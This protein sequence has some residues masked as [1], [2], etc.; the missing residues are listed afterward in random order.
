MNTIKSIG[1]FVLSIL[2]WQVRY[3][4]N[5]SRTKHSL[6]NLFSPRNYSE[7]IFRDNILGNHK[8]HAFLADK[9]EVRKYVKERGLGHILTKL[10]GV[11]DDAEK[12]K[13][14]LSTLFENDISSARPEGSMRVV[15]LFWWEHNSAS[16]N[17]PS[18]DLFNSVVVKKKE[19][20]DIPTKLDDYII[21][22]HEI[23]NVNCEIIV[24][25]K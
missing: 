24:D 15:K 3:F 19:D 20:V 1:R 2:P 6:P 7:Y 5:Y 17:V 13:Y 12:I 10:Y 11:W 23:S 21:D 4:L 25:K 14:A 9:Y 16:G 18:I 22:K 8:K